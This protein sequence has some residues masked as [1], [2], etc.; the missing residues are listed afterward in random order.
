MIR[1]NKAHYTKRIIEN[2]LCTT[3]AA[4]RKT[5]E[6]TNEYM[7]NVQFENPLNFNL[8]LSHR[9]IQKK[10]KKKTQMYIPNKICDENC[11]TN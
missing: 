2:F 3:F 9:R 5:T 1:I 6:K 4:G 11:V 8:K 7:I 10:M